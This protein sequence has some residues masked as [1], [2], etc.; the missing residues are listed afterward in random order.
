M[1]T[2]NKL[3]DG[4]FQAP[5]TWTL[6][7]TLSFD[8]DLVN[9]K[10]IAALRAVGVKVS[11]KGRIGVSKGFKSDLAS[12]PRALWAILA[13][14]DVARA[15]V[16]HD[17]IYYC[18]RQ[19]RAFETADKATWQEAKAIGDKVF[20]AGM[21][22]ANPQVPG[23]KIQSAYLAVKMFGRWSIVPREEL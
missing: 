9:E 22:S 4:T 10:E 6:N 3:L 18:I 20:K 17:Y 5:R 14:F 23:W 21:E 13:P 12:C 15:A 19:Y 1:G 8:C 2:F 7:S 16:I 11:A